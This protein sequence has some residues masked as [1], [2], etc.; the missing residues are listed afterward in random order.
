[1]KHTKILQIKNM[2]NPKI[3]LKNPEHEE[4]YNKKTQNF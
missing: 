2:K 3:Y 1:M 4:P